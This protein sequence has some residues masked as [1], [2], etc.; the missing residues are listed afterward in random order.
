MPS[1]KDTIKTE[2]ELKRFLIKINFNGPDGCWE[3]TAYKRI[4]GYGS[5][6]LRGKTWMAHRLAYQLFVGPI[7]E[8]TLDHLCYNPACVNPDHLNPCPRS[9]NRKRSKELKKNNNT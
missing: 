7:Q 1:N 8:E 5:Y 2:D 9:E 3:W 4:T 6:T